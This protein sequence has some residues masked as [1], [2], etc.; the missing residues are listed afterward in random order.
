MNPKILFLV[1]SSAWGGAERYVARLAEAA[2]AE[3]DVAVAA[4]HS[5][6]GELFKALEGKVR[7]FELAHLVHPIAPIRDLRAMGEVEEIIDRD[8]FDIIHCNSSKAGLVGAM[9]AAFSRRKPKVIYTA[10]GWGFLERRS[11]AFRTAVLL[12]ETLASRFRDATIVLSKLEA[13]VAERL[14]L[15]KG[16]KLR[17]IPL[18]VDP[19]EIAFLDREA[20]RAELAGRCGMRLDRTL[21][22]TIANAYPSKNLPML[23]RAFDRL[24]K[25]LPDTDL[26]VVGDGPRMAEL[27]AVR[28]ALPYRDRICLPGAVSEA[29]RLLKAFDLF[30]LPSTK[31]GLPWT[32]LEASLAGIP[33]IATRVGAIPEIVEDGA[34]GLLVPPGDEAALADAV[35]RALTDRALLQRL[36]SGAPRVAERLPATAM[37]AATLV[38]YRELTAAR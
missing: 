35:R 27:R 29:A 36:K 4:G 5:E 37:I 1:T 31:E 16:R 3:F 32:V 15:A 11:A 21:V 25:G 38:I 33:I 14:G 17:L 12:S 26:V 18:G 7:T 19:D 20:A 30:V 8:G 9:A 10:H 2:S 13:A 23:L 6:T 28:E 24:A 34:E 22:G